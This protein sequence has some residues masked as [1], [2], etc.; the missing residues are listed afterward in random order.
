MRIPGLRQAQAGTGVLLARFGATALP[1]LRPAGLRSPCGVMG[2]GFSWTVVSGF[3]VRTRRRRAAGKSNSLTSRYQGL[4]SSVMSLGAKDVVP[5]SGPSRC[6][7]QENGS[8]TPR[9]GGAGTC[10]RVPGQSPVMAHPRLPSSNPGDERSTCS[11][12]LRLLLTRRSCQLW[13]PRRVKMTD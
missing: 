11:E 7:P 2:R 8:P 10:P 4:P 12:A 9:R 3:V 6:R 5:H 13:P 1:R